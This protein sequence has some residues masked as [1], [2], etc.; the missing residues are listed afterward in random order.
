MGVLAVQGGHAE[1]V[2]D[3]LSTGANDPGRSEHYLYALEQTAGSG[4]AAVLD[5][6]IQVGFDGS[7]LTSHSNALV[8]A[9]RGGHH[10]V[11]DLHL[12]AGVDE[13]AAIYIGE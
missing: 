12:G 8:R 7:S 11:V 1:S 3:L 13:D 4:F 2:A 10:T 6:M 5:L 9:S